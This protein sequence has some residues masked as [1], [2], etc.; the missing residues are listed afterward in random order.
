MHD[1]VAVREYEAALSPDLGFDDLD[2]GPRVVA[3][4]HECRELLRVAAPRRVGQETAARVETDRRRE[5]VTLPAQ[6]DEEDGRRRGQNGEGEENEPGGPRS[7]A[8]RTAVAGLYLIVNFAC[9]VETLPLMS[10]AIHLNV[11]VDET[12]KDCPG[13]RG[14]VESQSVDE[15]VGFEP[16]VV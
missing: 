6:R 9:P 10:V 11:V 12:T 16:S 4:G 3:I 14:P 8:A 15:L 2:L 7:R 1:T 13:S 5:L